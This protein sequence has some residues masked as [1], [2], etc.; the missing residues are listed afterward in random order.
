MRN[1]Q[2]IMN[3]LD[4][5]KFKSNSLIWTEKKGDVVLY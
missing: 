3:K 1:W 4:H 5:A 2:T